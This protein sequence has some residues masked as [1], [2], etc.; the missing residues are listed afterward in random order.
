MTRFL[1]LRLLGLSLLA[2]AFTAS[3]ATAQPGRTFTPPPVFTPPPTFTPP[4][5]TF[6]PPSFT[7]PAQNFQFQQQTA[8]RQQDTQNTLRSQNFS[9]Q[10]IQS[11][12]VAQDRFQAE[13]SQRLEQ[14]QASNRQDAIRTSQNSGSTSSS[15]SSSS[16]GSSYQ[17]GG[18]TDYIPPRP[19]VEIVV[20]GVEPN[21]QSAR[22]G[23]Q[24]GDILVS[25]NGELLMSEVHLVQLMRSRTKDSDPVQLVIDRALRQIAFEVQPGRLGLVPRTQ[26]PG[27]R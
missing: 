26:M 19:T 12:R 20:L 17:G 16:S 8:Q 23:L 24:R 21:S 15:S 1:N 4:P 5:R 2:V 18:G 14:F 25:Y 27:T 9:Q 7:P 3:L 6:T 10:Q 11:Q 13:A 22:L